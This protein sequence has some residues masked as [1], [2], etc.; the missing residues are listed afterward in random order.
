MC[1]GKGFMRPATKLESYWQLVS[2][3]RKSLSSLTVWPMAGVAGVL[4]LSI[5]HLG[6]SDWTQ[7]VRKTKEDTELRRCVCGG[8][9]EALERE[10][11]E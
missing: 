2:S 3:G 1:E 5:E 8:F 4:Y 11:E 9:W 7:W 6:S 10:K